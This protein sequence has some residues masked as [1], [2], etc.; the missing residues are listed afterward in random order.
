[1]SF[2]KSALWA[3]RTS[4]IRIESLGIWNFTIH[5]RGGRKWEERVVGGSADQVLMLQQW[6]EIA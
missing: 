2:C 5:T 4:R 6:K 1:L 3:I